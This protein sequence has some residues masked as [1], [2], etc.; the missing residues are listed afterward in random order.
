M[1]LTFS[2]QNPITIQPLFKQSSYN[3]NIDQYQ[4]VSYLERHVTFVYSDGGSHKLL[5]SQRDT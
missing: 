2:D 4:I 5:Q 3:L 1:K